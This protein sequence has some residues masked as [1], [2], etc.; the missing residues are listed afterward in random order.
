MKSAIVIALSLVILSSMCVS[1]SETPA[2]TLP[3]ITECTTDCADENPCTI[4]YCNKTS[5]TCVHQAMDGEVE[6]CKGDT[7][8]CSLQRCFS[9]VCEERYVEGCCGN[10]VCEDGE[11]FADCR[12]DC[13]TPLEITRSYTTPIETAPKIEEGEITTYTFYN[14]TTLKTTFKNRYNE[15][16]KISSKLEI[17]LCDIYDSHFGYFSPDGDDLYWISNLTIKPAE[18]KTVTL[19]CAYH[20]DIVTQTNGQNETESRS[21]AVLAPQDIMIYTADNEPAAKVTLEKV[22]IT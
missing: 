9:G 11:N 18:E 7:G 19:G 1:K 8:K 16:L 6:G 13:R 22:S 15:T 12:E 14:S 3:T 4:D 5:G 20:T 2:A 10:S 17:S 21:L